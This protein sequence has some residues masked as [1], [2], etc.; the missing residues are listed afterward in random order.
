MILKEK[1]HCRF[2][3][4]LLFY[5]FALFVDQCQNDYFSRIYFFFMMIIF[6]FLILWLHVD[7][8]NLH[9]SLFINTTNFVT[10]SLVYNYLKF[11]HTILWNCLSIIKLWCLYNFN[12]VYHLSLSLSLSLSLILSKIHTGRKLCWILLDFFVS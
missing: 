1:I 7:I 12:I 8:L 2:Y 3:I 10:L 9:W 4:N 11:M 5:V 6:N